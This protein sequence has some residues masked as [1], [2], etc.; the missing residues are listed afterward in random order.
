MIKRNENNKPIVIN[1]KKELEYYADR[2]LAEIHY[3]IGSKTNF[4][5]V[6]LDPKE[7][8][9]HGRVLR[10]A[11]QIAKKINSKYKTNAK[12]WNSGGRGLHIEFNLKNEIGTDKLRNELKQ[13][14]DE[15]NKNFPKVSTKKTNDNDEMRADISTLHRTGNL[16]VG[17]SLNIK[18]GK[19]KIPIG[20]Q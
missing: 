10:Y 17:Y 4:G 7:K 18:G 14:C 1:D 20:K 8:F 12:I 5:W 6:D 2:R 15:L 3:V 13:M 9:P 19:I 11:K 16:R